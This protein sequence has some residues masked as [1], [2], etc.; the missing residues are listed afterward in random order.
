MRVYS[1][2]AMV[3]ERLKFAFWEKGAN[4]VV[5]ALVFVAEIK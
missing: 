5:G 1:P 4:I 2:P 3:A